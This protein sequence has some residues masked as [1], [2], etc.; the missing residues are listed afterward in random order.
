MNK[1]FIHRIMVPLDFSSLSLHALEVAA[2]L[3]RQH[4]ASL[5]M[6]QIL[7]KSRLSSSEEDSNESESDRSELLGVIKENLQRLAND[8]SEEYRIEV[9]SIV[10]LGVPADEICS[11]ADVLQMDLIIMGSHG[12]TSAPE[13]LVGTTAFRVAANAGCPVLTL[14]LHHPGLSLNNVL[15]PVRPVPHTS[16]NF[17]IVKSILAT[18]SSHV[19]IA[20]VN[21]KDDHLR[22]YLKMEK[23][24][25]ILSEKTGLKELS[26]INSMHYSDDVVRQ[27]MTIADGE[28]PDLIILTATMKSYWTDQHIDANHY[29]SIDHRHFPLLIL[30]RNANEIRNEVPDTSLLNLI[31]TK[32][33]L[34]QNIHLN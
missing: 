8:L 32:I 6:V 31:R 11:I 20:G 17:E 13:M 16:D 4:S 34:F 23:L 25:E 18:S 24:V 1:D 5:L 19:M 3:A 10:Q 33:R 26:C 28:Q 7:E 29:S 21:K 27:I 15:L 30:R 14:P 22:T 12:L 9:Q 2:T